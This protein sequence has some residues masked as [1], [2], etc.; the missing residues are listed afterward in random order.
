MPTY[1]RICDPPAPASSKGLNIVIEGSGGQGDD[2]SAH[3][4][5]PKW[6]EIKTVEFSYCRVESEEG[7]GSFGSSV[8]TPQVEIEKRV[9]KGSCGLLKWIGAMAPHFV[10]IDYCDAEG[11][12]FMKVALK[13]ARLLEFE[14]EA[15]ETGVN[16]TLKMIYGEILVETPRTTKDRHKEQRKTATAKGVLIGAPERPKRPTES[17]ADS[18]EAPT[19]SD[20]GEAT[21]APAVDA[22]EWTEDLVQDGRSPLIDKIGK[23]DFVLHSFRGKES[24]SRPFAFV[25]DVSSDAL[26]IGAKDVVGSPVG[27]RLEDDGK[28]PP[29]QK[30]PAREFHGIVREVRSGRFAGQRRFYTLVVVPWLWQ[31]GQRSDCRIFQNKSVKDVV[32]AVF[33]HYSHASFDLSKLGEYPQFEYCVQYRETDL[34]F[35]SRLLEEAGIFYFFDFTKGH[36]LIL[37]D[38]N[39]AQTSRTVQQSS[40]SLGEQQVFQWSK[41]LSHVPGLASLR[42]YNYEKPAESLNAQ[43]KSKVKFPG[44]EKYEIYDYP[45]RYGTVKRGKEIVEIRIQEAETRHCLVDGTSN[46]DSFTAGSRFK[47]KEHEDSR[48]KDKEYLLTSVEHSAENLSFPSRPRL[49]YINSFRCIPKEVNF[50]PPRITPRPIVNGPQTAQVV[51]KSADEIH[52][53][54]SGRVKV[55]FHWDRDEKKD[56]NSSCWVRVGQILAGKGWGSFWIPRIGQEVIVEFLEGDPDRPLVVGAVYNGNNTPPCDLAK[57]KTQTLLKS[58]SSKGG[59]PSENFNELRLEDEKGKEYVYLHAERDLV[60]VVE[61]DD[62]LTVGDVGKDDELADKGGTLKPPKDG[63]GSQTI[64]VAKDRTVTVKKGNRKTVVEKGTDELIVEGD[65]TITV[66]AGDHERVLKKGAD[67]L[68]VEQGRTVTLKKGNEKITLQM[69]NH[70]LTI[71]KG[72]STTDAKLGIELKVGANGI[73]ITPSGVT[74]TGTMVKIDAKVKAELKGGA[75]CKVEGG[76]ICDVKSGAILKAGGILTKIG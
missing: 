52:A 28:N 41:R 45:G 33:E 60:R 4:Q 8:E 76:A 16:E 14:S 66:N 26:D 15:K 69:G 34:Q 59:K 21:A 6:I 55:K 75:I 39:P 71:Q 53:D 48:E 25:L 3:P 31:L 27:F 38:G 12:S 43:V 64:V 7:G 30:T 20:E 61:N 11:Q 5:H 13:D 23:V 32:K 50:R 18:P 2:G 70:T 24:L 68:T 47:I 46:N 35:V 51:G 67:T 29:P 73:K 74:I 17:K 40:S 1:M 65:R 49:G 62:R 44:I 72:K 9:A 42:D 56:E 57:S 36:K 22:G 58:L 54:E 63:K 19:A 37:A 10:E